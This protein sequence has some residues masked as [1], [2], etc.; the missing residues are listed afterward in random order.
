MQM[1][2]GSATNA[3]RTKSANALSLRASCLAGRCRVARDDGMGL[4]LL[5][6]WRRQARA[7]GAV[8]EVSFVPVSLSWTLTSPAPRTAVP[9]NATGAL[10]RII[11]NVNVRVSGAVNDESLLV[12]VSGAVNDESL[13]NMQ[14][15]IRG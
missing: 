5:H 13:R 1:V 15:A 7:V 3:D 9:T 11:R 14:T 4:G 6:Y 8:E 10:D 2:N 12:R